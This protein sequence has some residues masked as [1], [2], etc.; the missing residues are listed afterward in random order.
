MFIF[1]K[2]KEDLLF[3]K[4]VRDYLLRVG[5]QNHQSYLNADLKSTPVE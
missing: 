1:N 5:V 4:L 2:K 3:E